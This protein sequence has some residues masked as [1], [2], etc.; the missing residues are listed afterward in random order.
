MF[1]PTSS[2][3]QAEV[4]NLTLVINS[5]SGGLA[6]SV[7]E[8]GTFTAM[9]SPE[10]DTLISLT[11]ETVTVTDTRRSAPG[12]GAW[13]TNASATNLLSATDTLT[14]STFGYE[15]GGNVRTGGLAT[16]TSH[17]RS[18]LNSAVMVENAANGTGNHVASWFPTLTIP[19]AGLKNPGTYTGTITHSVS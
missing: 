13:T 6:I 18:S 3:A 9:V 7:P 4:T 16:I 19:I 14:A 1:F 12:L 17:S 5:Y 8:T 2:P 10:T 15:S 11:L